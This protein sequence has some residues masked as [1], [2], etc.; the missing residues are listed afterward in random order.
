MVSAFFRDDS[1]RKRFDDYNAN[2]IKLVGITAYKSF[3]KPI[4]DDSGDSETTY[5]SFNYFEKIHH[6]FSCFKDPEFYGF[7][8]KVHKLIDLSESDFY[9]ANDSS[10]LE[11]KYDLIYICLGDDDKTCPMNGW[12]SI[13]RNFK[14]AL[15]CFPILIHELKLRILVIGRENC[16]LEKL[17]GDQ[18]TVMG[19]LPWNEFQDKIRESRILFVPNIYDASPR[20]IAESLSQGLPVLMNRAIVCGSK[21]I[22]HQT[23]ELFTDENDIRGAIQKLLARMPTMNTANWWKQNYSRKKS[24]EKLRNAIEEWFPG[25][26]SPSV[27][28][29]YFR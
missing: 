6:W 16:G 10:H 7:N 1:E 2:G 12:N 29:I 18:I 5:D 19:F 17:Y 22:V 11:K 28:E 27:K 4:T 20:V 15:A 13:N 26:I 8:T 25:F 9:D 21:Y 24:G 23:G 3:P 14:L